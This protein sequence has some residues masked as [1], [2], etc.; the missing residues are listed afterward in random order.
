MSGSVIE[1]KS[2]DDIHNIIQI[3]VSL[4]RYFPERQIETTNFERNWK[5]KKTK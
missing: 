3:P 1:D 2:N 5:K 4:A